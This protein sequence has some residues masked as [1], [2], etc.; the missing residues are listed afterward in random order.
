MKKLKASLKK[1]KKK[2][3]NLKKI[4]MGLKKSLKEKSEFK[5]NN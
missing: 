4:I 1:F 2:K 5:K 3:V